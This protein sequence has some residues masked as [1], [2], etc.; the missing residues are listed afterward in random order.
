MVI[1]ATDWLKELLLELP[2]IPKPVHAILIHHDNRAALAKKR[3]KNRTN[4]LK[5]LNTTR[6]I[7]LNFMKSVI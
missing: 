1:I 7:T 4:K 3:R 5:K 2:I 6:V